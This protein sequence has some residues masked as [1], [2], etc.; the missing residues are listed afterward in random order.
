LGSFLTNIELTQMVN[1]LRILVCE[2]F[3]DG[4]LLLW[5]EELLEIILLLLAD[6]N[7]FFLNLKFCLNDVVTAIVL[8]Q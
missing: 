4:Q 1:M 5:Y 3:V 8:Y 6:E 7:P 2:L